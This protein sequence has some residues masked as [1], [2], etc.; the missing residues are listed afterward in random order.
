MSDAFHYTIEATPP[1]PL[2]PGHGEIFPLV[3]ERRCRNCPL[4]RT[5]FGACRGRPATRTI[6]F[7]GDHQILD[8][9]ALTGKTAAA[10]IS[11]VEVFDL[12]GHQNTLEGVAAD[13][14]NLGERDLFVN[15]GEQQIV[16]KGGAG[17]ESICRT[18]TL[19]ASPMASGRS[20]APRRSAA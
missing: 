1:S 4:R 18:R 13:V 12:G 10:K 8:L 7:T 5:G 19:R 9:T 14:L 3:D 2:V 11:G 16:V 20:T 17:D 15:D 6:A